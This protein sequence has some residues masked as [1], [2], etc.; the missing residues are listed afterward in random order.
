MKVLYLDCF[1]G[2]SGDMW[3][4]SLLDLGLALEELSQY[5][6]SLGVSAELQQERCSYSGISAC[7][8]RVQT[9]ENPPLRRLSDIQKL[10]ELLP[11]EELRGQADAVFSCLAEAEAQVHGVSVNDIHFHEIG[12]VDTIVDVVGVLFGLRQLNI[13]AVYASPIPWPKGFVSIDH[14]I[15]PLP[16]PATAKL[17]C[18]IPCYGVDIDMEL[19]T[20]TGAAL[21]KTLVKGFG[22]LPACSPVAI[23]YGAGWKQRHDGV[24]NLVRAVLAEMPGNSS[25]LEPIT[26]L[27]CEIDD[28]NP[29]NFTYLFASLAANDQVKD[30]YVTSIQMKKNR[31]GFLLTLLCDPNHSRFLAEWLLVNTTSLGI[32]IYQQQ[33]LILPRWEEIVASPWGPIRC[34]KAQLPDGSF[35]CK[36]EYEDCARIAEQHKIPLHQV[37][38]QTMK[39]CQC[40]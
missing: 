21:L 24:P 16:A 39:S 3:I 27:E 32:R 30:F 4:S 19:V 20:P 37:Y 35:R 18:G 29:E 15:V 25:S 33:R 23:G 36:P 26:V 6:N 31:P 13:E 5:I 2:I 40:K 17:L 9:T 38:Y 10:L 11:D 1:S 8:F 7:R 22:P 34:K 14:G 12:A 28:M